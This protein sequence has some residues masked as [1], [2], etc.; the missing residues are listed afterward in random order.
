MA[1]STFRCAGTLRQPN[2]RSEIREWESRWIF[3]RAYLKDF[4]RPNPLL[5]A[6]IAAW[7]WDSPL[8]GTSRNYTVGLLRQRVREQVKGPRSRSEFRW[9]RCKKKAPAWHLRRLNTKKR[10]RTD[11]RWRV[12]ECWSWKTR[13]TRAN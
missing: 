10:L 6:L 8:S 3:C 2:S 12:C 1:G 13:L 4:A 7:A 11:S 5:P 9:R